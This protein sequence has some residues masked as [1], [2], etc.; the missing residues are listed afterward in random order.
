MSLTSYSF[1]NAHETTAVDAFSIALLC[2]EARTELYSGVLVLDGNRARFAMPDWKTT[3][4]LKTLRNRLKDM[5][6][7]AFKNPGRVLTAQHEKWLDVW[8]KIFVL[9][10]ENREAALAARAV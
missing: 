2:G 4:A 5:L 6:T 1:L 10:A 7:R 8:Q 9:A 3:L